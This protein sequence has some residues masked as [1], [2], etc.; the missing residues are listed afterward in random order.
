M[1][2][3][4]LFCMD[5]LLMISSYL[6]P[7]FALAMTLPHSRFLNDAS[8]HSESVNENYKM[9]D[10]WLNVVKIIS[11]LRLSANGYIIKWFG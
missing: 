11:S 10:I 2:I 5:G 9:I 6:F 8:T 1:C 7:Y 4:I 3:E